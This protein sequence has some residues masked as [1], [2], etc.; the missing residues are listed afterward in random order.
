MRD[1]LLE[2]LYIRL[3]V[4]IVY[5]EYSASEFRERYFSSTTKLFTKLLSHRGWGALERPRFF[6][7]FHIHLESAGYFAIHQR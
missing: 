2:M 7:Y 5:F 3:I 6:A 4:D 1:L